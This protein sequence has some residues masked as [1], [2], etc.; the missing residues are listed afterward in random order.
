[1]DKM[2][3]Q[4]LLSRIEY[5]ENENRLLE[6][7]NKNSN[8]LL[9]KILDMLEIE[10]NKRKENEEMIRYVR[11]LAT[12]NR[13]RINSMPY[14]ILD[15]DFKNPF[16]KPHIMSISETK[17]CLIED[18]MS[19]ARFGDCEFG[20]IDGVKRWNYQNTDEELSGRLIEV[21]NSEEK[22]LI[23]GLN[24]NFY[25]NLSDLPEMDAD[26]VRSYMTPSVRR[27]HAE[28][29]NPDKLYGAAIFH[30]L[31]SIDEVNYMKKLWDGRDC[32]FIEGRY[33]R[34]GVGNDLFDN[35]RSIER[36]L[37]PAE[38][39]YDRYDE[40]MD[41]ALREPTD[42]LV[43]AAL[44]PAATV[45]AFDLHKAGYQV[46]DVGHLDLI[47]EQYLRKLS[48]LDQLEIAYKYCNK[49]ETGDSRII[50]EVNDSVYES[51]IVAKIF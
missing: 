2:K 17:K 9:F 46:I 7:Y 35:S 22:G 12:V 8:I 21:L 41:A 28:L 13:W 31:E 40:I 11:Q 10:Q 14:E 19:I 23:I 1:M 49:D 30:R 39:A 34:M 3:L 48:G 32:V 45:L 47:Y 42:K 16:F 43:M 24:P 36:I 51:Q 38:N 5:L 18:G 6:E 29:L 50:P 27:R 26:G 25:R 33:T 44:G 20:I 4:E 15:P 37:C